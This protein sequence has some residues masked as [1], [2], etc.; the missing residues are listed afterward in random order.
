MVAEEDFPVAA[1]E[2]VGAARSSDLV[3]EPGV[4]A[5]GFFPCVPKPALSEV[6]G[7]PMWF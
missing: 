7:C 4:Q 3:A 1:S 2:A 5:C 6:E